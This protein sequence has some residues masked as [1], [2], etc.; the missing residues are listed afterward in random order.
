[1]EK[2]LTIIEYH[3]IIFCVVINIWEII[4]NWLD[5][6][7]S[8]C[9]AIGWGFREGKSKCRSAKCLSAWWF[10]V[11]WAD[12]ALTL[13]PRRHNS[14]VNQSVRKRFTYLIGCHLW[15]HRRNFIHYWCHRS[16]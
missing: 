12:A 1:V 14:N 15:S 4:F 5:S 16:S 8:Q 7:R 3:L 2:N 6:K 10:T 11:Q 9:Y 13:Q